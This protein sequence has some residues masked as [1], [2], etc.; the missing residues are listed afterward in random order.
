MLQ[1]AI[2][3]FAVIFVALG[4]PSKDAMLARDRF[5]E[6]SAALYEPS[7]LDIPDV[8][9]ATTYSGQMRLLEQKQAVYP[10]GILSPMAVAGKIPNAA[11]FMRKELFQWSAH[12]FF[13]GDEQNARILEGFEREFAAKT[14]TQPPDWNGLELA[15]DNP[16]N[17]RA[18]LDLS[19]AYIK[20]YELDKCEVLLG[21]YALPA[22]RVRG[23]PWII[24]GLQDFATLRMKQNRQGEALLA[25]EELESMVPPDPIMLHNLGIT[26]NSLQMPEKAQEKFKQAAVLQHGENGDMTYDNYWMMGITLKRK[27]DYEGAFPLLI[28]A[29]ELYSED[30]NADNIT[31]AKI[32]GDVGSCLQSA[33]DNMEEGAAE[34]LTLAS[35]AEVFLRDAVELYRV[36]VG[37]KHHLYGG[38][39]YPL[40]KNLI[41]QGR[42][43]EAEP[44]LHEAM[45]IEV[46]KNSIHPTPCFNLI[47]D[48]LDLHEKGGLP[49]LSISKY[50]DLLRVMLMHLYSRGFVADGNGG[51][52]MQVVAKFLLLSEQELVRPAL[53]LLRRSLVL[54]NNETGDF[55]GN[56]LAHI[57]MKVNADILK[58]ESILGL[59]S[60]SGV[61]QQPE[62]WL[63]EGSWGMPA[64]ADVAFGVELVLGLP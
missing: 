25:L 33:S 27:E 26:Y 64:G 49:K 19:L 52:I 37:I 38:A 39:S 1:S 16:E 2:P 4:D 55:P 56:A 60:A 50:H 11:E 23:K 6:I 36:S 13:D 61:R 43:V 8:V 46:L 15:L 29:L 12:E 7:I 62:R 44:V 63:F 30:P 10:P 51:V 35:E 9:A 54:V 17:L 58:A 53:A 21:R 34:K 5:Q 18:S 20:S 59:P 24:K 14:G 22:S 42:V 47:M 48:L 3:A 28:K 57:R 41:S 32:N 40:A 45:W 31:L